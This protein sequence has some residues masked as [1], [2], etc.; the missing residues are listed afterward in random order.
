MNVYTLLDQGDKG[1]LLPS[2][3]CT[4]EMSLPTGTCCLELSL[5]GRAKLQPP[6]FHWG[7]LS[8]ACSA[9]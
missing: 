5:G 2:A 3:F 8:E 4:T 6:G 1:W 7:Y 9:F